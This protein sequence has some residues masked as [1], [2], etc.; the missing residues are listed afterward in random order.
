MSNIFKVTMTTPEQR[1]APLLLTLNIFLTL[2]YCYY[3]C[4]LTNKCI[5]SREIIVSDKEFAFSNCQKY[6]VLW[7][8]E[9]YWATSFHSYLPN[10]RLRKDKFSRQNFKKISRTLWWRPTPAKLEILVC[11]YCLSFHPVDIFS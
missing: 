7:P 6:I 5:W 4:I 3:C 11:T 10:I 1:L 2:F 9:I 8:G